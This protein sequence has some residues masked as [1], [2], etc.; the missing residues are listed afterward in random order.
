MCDNSILQLHQNY[1]ILL[2]LSN[3]LTSYFMNYNYEFVRFEFLM[4]DIFSV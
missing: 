3:I 1:S 4:C 2:V